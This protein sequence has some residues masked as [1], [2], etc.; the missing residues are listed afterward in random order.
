MFSTHLRVKEFAGSCT[1]KEVIELSQPALC[2]HWETQFQICARSSST[3][4]FTCIRSLINQV[5]FV[6]QKKSLMRGNPCFVWCGH[7]CD[8]YILYFTEFTQRLSKTILFWLQECLGVQ[9]SMSE[10]WWGR[11]SKKWWERQYEKSPGS[12]DNISGFQ[13][14]DGNGRM[15]RLY[16]AYLLLHI[17]ALCCALQIVIF[18]VTLYCTKIHIFPIQRFLILHSLWQSIVCKWRQL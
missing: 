18:I 7:L 16:S 12:F 3:W 13:W 8:W 17:T 10:K 1:R 4:F 9:I 5:N 15:L 2:F 11:I 14:E 6:V